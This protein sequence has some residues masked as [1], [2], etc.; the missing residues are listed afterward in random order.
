MKKKRHSLETIMRIL[1][2]SHGLLKLQG[3]CD[4]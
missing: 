4:S 3:D 2:M 1:E